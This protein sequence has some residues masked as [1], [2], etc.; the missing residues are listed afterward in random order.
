[1]NVQN[2]TR[3]SKCTLCENLCILKKPI[4]LPKQNNY[5]YIIYGYVNYKSSLR[6]TC[7]TYLLSWYLYLFSIPSGSILLNVHVFLQQRY[8]KLIFGRSLFYLLCFYHLVYIWKNISIITI[9]YIVIFDLVHQIWWLYKFLRTSLYS[10]SKKN[11]SQ[12]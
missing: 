11:I 6:K 12:P 7:I 10:H 1:M 2:L 8:V 5:L 9:K 4:S 3:L